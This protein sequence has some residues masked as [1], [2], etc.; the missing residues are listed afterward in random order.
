MVL[1]TSKIDPDPPK[2]MLLLRREHDF[3]KIMFFFSKK[4]PSK[5][6]PKMTPNRFPKRCLFE[7]FVVFGGSHFPGPPNCASSP[8]VPLPIRVRRRERVCGRF[9][10]VF[11]GGC[12]DFRHLY[13][14]ASFVSHA[15]FPASFI[16]FAKSESRAKVSPPEYRSKASLECCI[17]QFWFLQAPS[18]PKCA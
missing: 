13:C 15:V 8:P 17:L 7:L 3:Q 6:T 4:R 9:W 5:K 18:P 12:G 1:G 11:W 14:R 16:F 10:M 2:S